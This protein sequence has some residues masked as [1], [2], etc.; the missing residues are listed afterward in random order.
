MY[1]CF[2]RLSTAQSFK[3][4]A[5]GRSV[6]VN[7]LEAAEMRIEDGGDLHNGIFVTSQNIC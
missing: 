2:F 5:Q 6:F 4:V 1:E 3:T 7:P